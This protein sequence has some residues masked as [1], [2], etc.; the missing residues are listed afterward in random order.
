MQG[1]SEGE[2]R[3]RADRALTKTYSFTGSAVSRLL[4]TFACCCREWPCLMLRR[5][6]SIAPIHCCSASSRADV[7][8]AQAGLRVP[9]I[10]RRMPLT[11]NRAIGES[12]ARG[13]NN[14]G[15]RANT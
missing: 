5:I 12:T 8:Y 2:E 3:A 14:R 11:L 9:V 7:R 6:R 10:W 15:R 1:T 4:M 13:V